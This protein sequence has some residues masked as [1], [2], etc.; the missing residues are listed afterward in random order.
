MFAL[1]IQILNELKPCANDQDKKYIEFII[2][3]L[4][5]A[6]IYEIVLHIITNGGAL[7]KDL[8][9]CVSSFRKGDY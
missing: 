3:K 4:A 8:I 5:S 9:D 7:F 2:A 1:I 6:N